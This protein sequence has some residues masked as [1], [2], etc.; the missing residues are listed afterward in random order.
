MNLCDPYTV[1]RDDYVYQ[2]GTLNGQ[3]LCVVSAIAVLQT[4]GAPGAF[5]RLHGIG[6]RLRNGIDEICQRRSI[7]AKT[8]SD[9]PMCFLAFCATPIVDYRTSQAANSAKLLAFHQALLDR[10]VFIMPGS[11]AY[12]STAHTEADIDS[13]LNAVDDAFAALNFR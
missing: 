10:G 3:V 2:S 8:Y 12:L 6:R 7:E 9:G 1:S 5:E 4:L 11:K 13:A